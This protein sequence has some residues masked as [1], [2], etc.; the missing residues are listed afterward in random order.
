MAI[1]EPDQMRK[2]LQSVFDGAG[3]SVQWIS[4]QQLM[5]NTSL[6]DKFK[7]IG[8]GRCG[9]RELDSGSATI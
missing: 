6:E 9:S 8:A 2:V 5:S 1:L 3:V 4:V 7:A